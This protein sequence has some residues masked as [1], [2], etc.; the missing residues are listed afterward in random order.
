MLILGGVHTAP[1]GVGHP[2]ELGLVAR[3]STPLLG[4]RL[5][6]RPS[7]SYCCH[8]DPPPRFDVERHLSTSCLGFLPSG[9]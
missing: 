9:P 5:G 7:R 1:K 2:P 8:G 3:Q 4:L 6:V